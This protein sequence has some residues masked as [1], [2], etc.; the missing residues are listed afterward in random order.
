[1]VFGNNISSIYLPTSNIFGICIEN[2]VGLGNRNGPFEYSIR[3]LFLFYSLF[4]YYII[5]AQQSTNYTIKGL[6]KNI[7]NSLL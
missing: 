2:V 3:L 5:L 4:G 6:L 1:M 7:S